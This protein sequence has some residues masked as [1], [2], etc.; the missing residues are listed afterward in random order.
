[1][2]RLAAAASN[3]LTTSATWVVI[4]A[5]T[6][7]VT[8]GGTSQT[9]LTTSAQNSANITPNA[10]I[11]IDAVAIRVGSVGG[12]TGTLTMNL[13]NVTSTASVV[14]VNVPIA[15]LP[16]SSN[17]EGSRAG[18]FLI[19]TGDQNLTSGSNYQI[20][21]NVS[22]GSSTIGIQTNGTAANWQHLLRTKTAAAPAAGDDLFVMGLWTS[23]GTWTQYTVTMD[24]TT[25]GTVYGSNP[26]AGVERSGIF[27]C[28]ST[29]S[30]ANAGSTN[31][32]LAVAGNV[33]I[34]W[35]G[36]WE[37]GTSGTPCSTTSTMTLQFNTATGYGLV[38]N[39][40]GTVSTFGTARTTGKDVSWTVLT[41]DA[42]SG[43]TVAYSV[44]HDTG[45]TSGNTCYISSTSPSAGG[46]AA[47]L[48]LT[49]NAG[50]NSIQA[51]TASANYEGTWP[52][53]AVLALTTMNVVIQS[54]ASTRA[55]LCKVYGA[56]AWNAQWLLFN[57]GGIA[58]SALTATTAWRYVCFNNKAATLTTWN[59]D[60]S[61]TCSG[62]VSFKDIVWI[63]NYNGAGVAITPGTSSTL[64]NWTIND[65][66]LICDGTSNYLQIAPGPYASCKGLRCLGGD[67]LISPQTQVGSALPSDWLQDSWQLGNGGL[68]AIALFNYNITGITISGF[69]AYNTGGGAGI[70]IAG[71]NWYN[72]TFS[73]CLFILSYNPVFSLAG[74]FSHS[75]AV[76]SNCV[77]GSPGA[78][79]YT[80]FGTFGNFDVGHCDYTFYNCDLEATT[81]SG[82]GPTYVLALSSDGGAGAA[83]D[84][85]ISLVNCK[86][87]TTSLVSGDASG[88]YSPWSFVSSVNHNRSNT[89]HRITWLAKGIGTGATVNLTQTDTVVYNTAAPSE[90]MTPVSTAVKLPSSVK[91]VAITSGSTA[92]ISVYVRKSAAYNGN[93]P[94]LIAKRNDA[95]G[96]TTDTVGDT[97]T[98]AVE[99]W[100]QLVYVTPTATGDGVW[101]FY[102]DCD[103][104]AGYINVDDWSAA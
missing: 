53:P 84:I 36:A 16:A 99:N 69:R 86:A 78:G 12:T 98:A 42:S 56:G 39:I 65:I 94:R 27:V 33:T 63:G 49:A 18:W 13:Y 58:F 80:L 3:N 72:V 64:T 95:V 40:G 9:N 71:G 37:M 54:D 32:A 68:G 23:S 6:A 45:W 82:V 97:M 31:Y 22:S 77:F 61:G 35:G 50:T 44:Q 55:A 73:D 75:G 66:I 92:S 70:S 48:T 57:Y 74:A 38:C 17:A 89:D 104:T 14:S 100:E 81:L 8:E 43:S 96:L 26:G 25:T 60:V 102:V 103:G 21:L 88:V 59:F 24:Q 62:T 2:A 34:S 15:D 5:Q 20:R 30:W 91:R 1:M 67:G 51:T 101:E 46:E 76:F 79:A 93:Q 10:N 19:A 52:I 85:R 83:P 4:D 28:K 90:K 11:T 7:L 41:A 29:V 87:S 47:E